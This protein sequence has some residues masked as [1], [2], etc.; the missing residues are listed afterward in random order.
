MHEFLEEK[1]WEGT[2]DALASKAKMWLDLKRIGDASF[3]PNERLVRDYVARGILSRPE[4]KGKEALF[5]FE[6]LVQFLACRAM[7]EDGWPLSQVADEFQLSNLENIIGWIPGESSENEALGLVK[8]FRLNSE[9][10]IQNDVRIPMGSKNNFVEP[11]KRSR[12]FSNR[13]RESFRNKSQISMLLQKIGSELTAPLMEEHT[14]FQLASWMVLFIEREKANKITREDAENIGLAVTATLLEKN[15][16]SKR[17]LRPAVEYINAISKYK[18][19]LRDLQNTISSL[20]SAQHQINQEII[21]SRE[22][23]EEE[24]H[25]EQIEAEK[26]QLFLKEKEKSLAQK[27]QQLR[28]LEERLKS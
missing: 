7:I 24:R 25:K 16:L 1:K 18:T 15:N 17:D 26:R 27:E 22:K 8:K 6:Q 12:D 11:E 23:A 13:R 10:E 20:R 5:G 14:A 2:A 3:E 21:Q 28:E 9:R 4:R 19:E